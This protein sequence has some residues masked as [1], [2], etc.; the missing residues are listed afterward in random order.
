MKKR[1]LAFLLAVMCVLS[2]FA[3]SACGDDDTGDDLSTEA[4]RADPMTLTLCLVADEVTETSRLA[5]QTA[6]NSI[7]KADLN[8]NVILTIKTTAE[9]EAY[10]DAQFAA[11]A[12]GT[13][14][15]IPGSAG[16]DPDADTDIVVQYPDLLDNQFDVL[17]V[18]GYDNF[19]KY[20]D[21]G[22]LVKLD[23]HFNGDEKIITTFIDPLA[24]KAGRLSKGTY[25]IPNR[26][27]FGKYTY[28]LLDKALVDA[29][30]ASV[31]GFDYTTVKSMD[32]LAPYLNKMQELKM[33]GTISADTVILQN[34]PQNLIYAYQ[35]TLL[36]ASACFPV[37]D[38][39][40][41]PNSTLTKENTTPSSL[42][43][44]KD[45]QDYVIY[46]KLL[47][48][49]AMLDAGDVTADT[50]C[51]AAFVTGDAISKKAYEDMG[52]YVVE[53]AKPVATRE[54]LCETMFGISKYTI[55][56]ARSAELLTLLATDSRVCNLLAYG[57]EDVHYRVVDD[58]IELIKEGDGDYDANNRYLGN[59]LY[60]GNQFLLAR[61]PDRM[62]ED[63]LTLSADNWDIAAKQNM[64]MTLNIYDAFD[65]N[66]TRTTKKDPF[67]G[68]DTLEKSITTAEMLTELQTIS[69]TINTNIAG[70]K[71]FT[72]YQVPDQTHIDP[73]TGDVVVDSWRTGTLDEYVAEFRAFMAE[74]QQALLE[75][76]RSYL[77]ATNYQNYYRTFSIAGQY[78]TWYDSNMK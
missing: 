76:D 34:L 67:T 15:A 1:M 41:Y 11:V 16:N 61:C 18:R 72:G 44:N 54:S 31:T 21:S 74:D 62:T 35:N 17:L 28:L 60:S 78:G 13:G 23:T 26:H 4:N 3:F 51:V 9:Y 40:G 6:L 59:L 36:G 42:L 66:T 69:A 50:D 14:A 38:A 70:F 10:V 20:T 57:I 32:A 33:G 27:V 63:M 5:L 19:K 64:E 12:A 65:L 52:Y 68:K 71:G 2:V 22:N 46:S 25:A 55:S 39:T 77:M 58:V 48:E 56:E 49:F 75:A 8:T 53:Y 43:L 30:A 45:Y 29:H 73:S 24:M 37:V 47:N 7:T